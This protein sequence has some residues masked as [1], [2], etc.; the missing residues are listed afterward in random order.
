MVDVRYVSMSTVASTDRTPVSCTCKTTFLTPGEESGVIMSQMVTGLPPNLLR[1]NR[2]RNP[3]SRN[4][5]LVK[6][7][8]VPGVSFHTTPL[9]TCSPVGSTT[10]SPPV[11]E[12]LLVRVTSTTRATLG[13]APKG[14]EYVF[15]R[16][17]SPS[18]VR[19]GLQARGT[20]SSAWTVSCTPVAPIWPRSGVKY[21]QTVRFVSVY[22]YVPS[23]H[24]P[25]VL[26]SMMGQG[27][28]CQ[29]AFVGYQLRAP[30][31]LVYNSRTCKLAA[32]TAFVPNDTR[33]HTG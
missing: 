13:S 23:G 8:A 31:A 1:M 14:W 10:S 15:T 26:S 16:G 25:M 11:V 28:D 9:L 30:P 19:T 20:K 29:M 12:A 24:M 6:A 7:P 21:T 2:H 3:P 22:R 33:S 5:Q 18:R 17:K 32:E 4:G 27:V